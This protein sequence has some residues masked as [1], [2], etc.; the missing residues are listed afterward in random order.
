M[1]GKTAEKFVNLQQFKGA[2]C[3]LT[4][5]K[6]FH[7]IKPSN[8]SGGQTHGWILLKQKLYYISFYSIFCSL[9][10]FHREWPHLATILTSLDL[11]FE[12]KLKS[13]TFELKQAFHSEKD[14]TCNK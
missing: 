12:A 1:I 4:K 3:D 8:S 9:S 6:C 5:K 7:R 10:P 14:L 2:L 11:S 13:S